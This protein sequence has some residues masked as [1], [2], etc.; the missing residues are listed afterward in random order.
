MNSEY[1]WAVP[2][3]HG[4]AQWPWYSTHELFTGLQTPA[5][6][7]SHEPVAGTHSLS[8]PQTEMGSPR[9][10]DLTLDLSTTAEG[11][12]TWPSSRMLQ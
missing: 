5:G 10:Q 1:S 12:M 2:H 8:L 7:V 4:P 3:I 11:T 9:W 6:E